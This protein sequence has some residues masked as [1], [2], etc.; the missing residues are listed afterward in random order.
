MRA[1]FV[2][3]GVAG[4]MTPVSVLAA[5]GLCHFQATGVAVTLPDVSPALRFFEPASAACPENEDGQR[6]LAK[7]RAEYPDSM[8]ALSLRDHAEALDQRLAVDLRRAERYRSALERVRRG[9]LKTPGKPGQF[10]LPGD[11]EAGLF[12]AEVLTLDE[13]T[14]LALQSELVA[15]QLQRLREAYRSVEPLSPMEQGAI[16]FYTQGDFAD[17]NRAMRLGGKARECM[18]PMADLLEAALA[19]LPAY[20]GVLWRGFSLSEN[21]FNQFS[22]Q[23]R[24]GQ[25]VDLQAFSSTSLISEVAQDFAERGFLPRRVVLLLRSRSCR[26]LSAFNPGEVEVICLPGTRFRVASQSAE[27]R[28]IWVEEAGER[29]R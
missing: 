22:K 10:I 26:D 24:P 12:E 27:N 15:K 3:L 17:L 25:V 8:P 5:S 20:E 29:S 19:K 9:E 1:F 18:K 11:E 16:R 28:W 2:L 21:E 7:I 23:N 4:A 13:L 6:L 14:E